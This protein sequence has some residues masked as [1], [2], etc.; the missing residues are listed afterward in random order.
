MRDG[1]QGDHMS[2]PMFDFNEKGGKLEFTAL[3]YAVK[4]NNFELL[5]NLLKS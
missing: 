1:G 3:H 5:I 4:Q 2:Y